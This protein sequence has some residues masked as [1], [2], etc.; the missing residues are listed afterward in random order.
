[1][2]ST[3]PTGPSSSNAL[4]SVPPLL[5]QNVE[6]F[7]KSAQFP[8]FQQFFQRGFTIIRQV[9]SSPLLQAAN[10]ILQF[11]MYRYSQQAPSSLTSPSHSVKHFQQSHTATANGLLKS[12]HGAMYCVG[13]ICQDVD[14]LALYFE[15]G[16]SQLTQYLL[17]KDDVAHP[18]TAQ[19]RMTFPSLDCTVE[20]PALH[21]DQW[22]V[23]GF[24][25]QGDHSP[26]SLLLAVAL[27]DITEA[28]M[29]NI[30]VHPESHMLLL[31]MFKDHVLYRRT[32][33]SEDPSVQPRPNL[34]LPQQVGFS[35][36]C[37]VTC[38]G[39]VSLLT[40]LLCPSPR[41]VV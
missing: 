39:R 27:T 8:V 14:L 19:I 4:E 16:L 1:M 24:N 28:D 36:S 30:C 23:E 40:P 15:S 34:G 21:G 22:I 6:T 33:F 3:A 29:G 18:K 12:R 38:A 7:Q 20:S 32:Q 9:V 37:A 31:D 35:L 13:D 10:K 26:F 17:G 25:G 41:S 11:W 2:S 5:T